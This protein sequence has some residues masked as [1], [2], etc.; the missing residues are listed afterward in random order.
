MDHKDSELFWMEKYFDELSKVQV[1]FGNQKFSKHCY[2]K[3][4]SRFKER[5]SMN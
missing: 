3:I 2:D 4:I 5:K 1:S